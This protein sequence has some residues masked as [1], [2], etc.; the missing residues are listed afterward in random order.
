VHGSNY[1]VKKKSKLSSFQKEQL[2]GGYITTHKTKL[3]LVQKEAV[4]QKVESI[5]SEIPIVDAVMRK[6]SIES[7]FFLVSSIFL[8]SY[9]SCRRMC[10]LL[11]L[12]QTLLGIYDVNLGHCF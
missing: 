12:M 3:T 7:S 6:S 8:M 10:E 2:K 5:H 4:K 11:I 1:I 9:F